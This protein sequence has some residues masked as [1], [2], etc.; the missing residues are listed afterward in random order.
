MSINSTTDE[1]FNSD[2]RQLNEMEK[3]RDASYDFLDNDLIQLEQR[4][5]EVERFIIEQQEKQDSSKTSKNDFIEK[6]KGKFSS[7]AQNVLSNVS[8][9]SF[10]NT[11]AGDVFEQS[12]DFIEA[13][14]RNSMKTVFNSMFNSISIPT[15]QKETSPSAYNQAML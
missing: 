6:T 11:S 5:D 14:R 8:F 15:Y 13:N 12:T 3:L 10:G 4:K 9:G 1:L 2:L 7:L